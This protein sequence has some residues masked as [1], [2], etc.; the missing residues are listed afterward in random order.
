MTEL[1]RAI[2]GWEEEYEASDQGRIRSVERTVIAK[3]PRGNVRPRLYSG[4]ILRTPCCAFGYPMVVLS[5]PKK[6]PTHS[7]V[8]DLVLLAFVGPKPEG[9]EV[10]H[11]DG[12]RTNNSIINLRY[13][14][15]SANAA[16]SRRLQAYRPRRGEDSPNA[17]LTE[18]LVRAIRGSPLSQRKTA[19]FLG[20]SRGAVNWALKG[21]QHVK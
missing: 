6:K 3:D 17:I 14:T 9:L 16:D 7:Y 10:C 18:G 8:H 21:W 4:R 1:W 19:A 12:I 20:I 15:R 5:R 2:P 13:D 11:Y